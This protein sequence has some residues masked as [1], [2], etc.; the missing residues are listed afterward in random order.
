M[1]NWWDIEVIDFHDTVSEHPDLVTAR[2][3]FCHR[4]HTAIYFGGEPMADQIF[5]PTC[6]M[7]VVDDEA[8]LE[9]MDEEEKNDV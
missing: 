3:P 5:C 9:K 7:K 6:G 8:K 1:I 2:C 4:Y